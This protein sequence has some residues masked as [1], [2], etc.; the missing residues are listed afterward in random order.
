MSDTELIYPRQNLPQSALG[1]VASH[2]ELGGEEGTKVDLFGPQFRDR[3][4]KAGLVVIVSWEG[5][6]EHEL[7]YFVANFAA[8]R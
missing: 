2:G 8:G 4:P 7:T 6:T 1:R 3:A 5:E